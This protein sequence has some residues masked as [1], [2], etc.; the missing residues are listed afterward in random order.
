MRWIWVMG[1][2]SW[3]RLRSLWHRVPYDANNGRAASGSGG[4]EII[5]VIHE[6][7]C[8]F[9][10]NLRCRIAAN[11]CWPSVVRRAW[12]IRPRAMVGSLLRRGPIGPGSRRGHCE[13]SLDQRP[14]HNGAGLSGQWNWCCAICCISSGQPVDG[15]NEALC[16][17]TSPPS[18]RS[19]ERTG[20]AFSPTPCLCRV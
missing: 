3:K 6:E 17:P 7:F 8:L 20:L 18:F 5:E 11:R 9:P 13:S 1:C 16:A 4:V 12:C 15:F 14:W 19:R 2:S 10:M